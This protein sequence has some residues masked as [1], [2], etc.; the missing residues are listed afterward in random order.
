MSVKL[1]IILGLSALL[2]VASIRAAEGIDASKISP[3]IA[4]VVK[5]HE[6]G[7][8]P[9]VLLSYVRETAVPKPNAEEVLYMTDK[10][11]P[12]DVI[13]TLLSKKV[14]SDTPAPQSQPQPQPAATE[15]HSTLPPAVST[16]QPAT[17]SV[18]Y[19]QQ[20]AP[21]VTYVGAPYY[22]PY[23]PYYPYYSYPAVSV[24]IGFGYGYGWGHGWHGGGWGHS[25]GGGGIHVHHR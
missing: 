12:K 19:V 23:Y 3:G 21:A 24:G 6:A 11:I 10:G 2:G 13:V 16:A 25:H 17:Q 4:Q 5:M 1:A 14:W 9:E 22:Y 7:V 8:A 20:P 15:N 18:V